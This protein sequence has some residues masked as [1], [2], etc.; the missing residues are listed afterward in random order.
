MYCFV[1][2]K[3]I[4]LHKNIAVKNRTLHYRNFDIFAFKNSLKK[5]LIQYILRMKTFK[6]I[7]GYYL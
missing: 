6:K 4:Q 1:H 7:F 5:R 2:R 3:R